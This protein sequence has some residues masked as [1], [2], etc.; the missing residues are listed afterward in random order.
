MRGSA[1]LV[2]AVLN[3]AYSSATRI[4]HLRLH[5]LARQ[6]RLKARP[7]V[8]LLQ[9]KQQ[10]WLNTSP[11]QLSVFTLDKSTEHVE[12]EISTTTGETMNVDPPG[13][14]ALL[15]SSEMYNILEERHP[16]RVLFALLNT[17][18]GHQFIRQADA[19][20]FAEAFTAIDPHYFLE[21]IKEV[22]RFMKPSLSEDPIYR[23]V[24]SIN[25]RLESFAAQ[26]DT[27]IS[28]RRDAGHK[29]NLDAFRHLLECAGIMGDAKIAKHVLWKMM[30]DDAVEPD[31]QCYN[32]YMEACCWSNAWSDAEQWRLR[33]T[34]RILSIRGKFARPPDLKGHRVGARIGIRHGMLQI[35]K[36]LVGKGYK[37]DE[38]TFT[39][40][41]VAMG[42]EHDLEGVKSIL[43]SV[44]NIDVIL[45]QQ[46]D[47]E[48]LETPT[49]YE[50]DSPLRPS[51]R[52]LFTVAHVF[53]SNNEVSLAIQLVDYISRYYDLRIPF[54]VW[55]HL[56]EWTFVLRLE[57]RSIERKQGQ[58]LGKIPLQSLDRLWD[59]MTDMPHNAKPDITMLALR[60]RAARGPG[61]ARLEDILANVRTARQRLHSKRKDFMA[62]TEAM[63]FFLEQHS[64]ELEAN[65]VLGAD[66]FDIRRK[67]IM[68]TLEIDR[69][70]QVLIVTLRGLFTETHGG[71]SQPEQDWQRRILPQ[72]LEEFEEFLPNT[73]V[74]RTRGGYVGL[75]PG[76][77]FRDRVNNTLW[78][79][80]QR[81]NGIIRAAIDVDDYGKMVAGIRRLPAT[82]EAAEAPCWI[83][84]QKGHL[85]KDCREAT[86]EDREYIS[87]VE[88]NVTFDPKTGKRMNS[89]PLYQEIQPDE[90]FL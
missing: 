53:G 8:K 58:D 6:S 62:A 44:Y 72:L 65:L 56:F 89:Q 15:T 39:S 86:A 80:Q 27:I 9:N 1:P 79:D 70:L 45:L 60:A 66:W 4:P 71:H 10:R 36:E 49:V 24:R 61:F 55:M 26:L 16:D 83:C 68:G 59:V 40:L 87:S 35:F 14:A 2:G 88:R 31:L 64:A 77:G 34:P 13:G 73:I 20:L 22:Y 12:Q 81:K 48:E 52:L 57:R 43:K 84:R 42:R 67:F 54:K 37:G 29:L 38:A 32:H 3:P 63:L 46:L 23:R 69:D 90:T 33:V 25:N 85:A 5:I 28:A 19:A 47:E 11:R 78:Q 30:K 51:A 74:Y 50:V 75:T 82:L 7:Q 17:P 21:P 18:S 76:K 41:M